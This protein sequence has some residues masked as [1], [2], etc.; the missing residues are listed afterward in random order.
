MANKKSALT[1]LTAAFGLLAIGMYVGALTGSMYLAKTVTQN[2]ANTRSVEVADYFY[3][4]YIERDTEVKAT[5]TQ[6]VTSHNGQY[7]WTLQR[8]NIAPYVATYEAFMAIGFTFAAITFLATAVAAINSY[9]ADQFTCCTPCWGKTII[10]GASFICVAAGSISVIVFGGG[11]PN[12]MEADCA[13]I[14]DSIIASPYRAACQ[15]N[16]GQLVSACPTV[17]NTNQGHICCIANVP[18]AATIL[19]AEPFCKGTKAAYYD[20]FVGE[21]TYLF[22]GGQ[23]KYTWSAGAGFACQVI[24]LS[25]AGIVF[26]LAVFEAWCCG[27][28]AVVDADP[29]EGADEK[30]IEPVE[31]EGTVGSTSGSFSDE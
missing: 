16:G 23:V 21:Q 1:W 28:P 19:G 25:A 24:A 9:R 18:Q 5:A 4:E 11:L 22:P 13:S 20:S 3:P 2:T 6:T 26:L 17:S 8:E 7:G 29:F 12:A 10:I 31:S 27:E 30:L 14:G 15:F